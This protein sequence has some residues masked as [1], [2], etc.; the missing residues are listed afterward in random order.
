MY[1]FLVESFLF[2]RVWGDGFICFSPVEDGNLLPKPTEP[3]PALYLSWFPRSHP[4]RRSRYKTFGTED[5]GGCWAWG[6]PDP[7][8]WGALAVRGGED[9]GCHRSSSRQTRL[10]HPLLTPS[11]EAALGWDVGNP[12]RAALFLVWRLSWH[13]TTG[14]RIQA[15]LA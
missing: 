8:R 14:W 10:L 3:F 6:K 11:G 13:A 2:R 9:R 7:R 12:W 1:N 4:L 15:I 5:A